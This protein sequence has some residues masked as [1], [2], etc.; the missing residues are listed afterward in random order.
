MK[1]DQH[2]QIEFI[3]DCLLKGEERKSILQKFTKIYK[4]LS[5]KTFDNRMKVAKEQVAIEF[6]QITGQSNERIKEE[7]EARKTKILT[8]LERQEILSNIAKGELERE[9]VVFVDGQPKKLKVKPTFN[10][11]RGAIA[12]LNKMQGDYAPT[13]SEVSI[14]DKPK[15]IFP[16]DEPT[17]D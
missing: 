15:I 4:G 10:D 8:A 5:I 3:K 7:V 17:D 16:G 13:K 11:M 14:T 6:K 12:E 2:T 1:A 9:D